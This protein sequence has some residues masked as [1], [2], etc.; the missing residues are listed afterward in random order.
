MAS[1][2][3][4]ALHRHATSRVLLEYLNLGKWPKILAT[5]LAAY[6]CPTRALVVSHLHV[7]NE[8]A[9]GNGATASAASMW[10]SLSLSYGMARES[11][12][13]PDPLGCLILWTAK[14]VLFP[15]LMQHGVGRENLS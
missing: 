10:R 11:N 12:Y 3:D 6:A 8:S 7:P 4:H 1:H 14:P 2:T 15:Q 9:F 13:E 5:C